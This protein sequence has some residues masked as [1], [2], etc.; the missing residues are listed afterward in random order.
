[1]SNYLSQQAVMTIAIFFQADPEELQFVPLSRGMSNQSFRLECRGQSYH[2]RQP[3][4][5][6][7]LINREHEAAVY[8]AIKPYG[9]CDSPLFLDP[10][11]GFKLSR[12]LPGA[13]PCDPR[14]GKDLDLWLKKIRQLHRA[15]LEVGHAFDLFGQISHYEALWQGCPSIYPDYQETKEKVFE[16]QN[17]I[18]LVPKDWYLTHLDP[19]FDNCLFYQTDGCEQMQL[20][21]WEYAGMQDPHLDLAMFAIYAGYSQ[22]EVDQLLDKYFQGPC[23]EI[24]KNKIYCY[25]AACGLLWSNW[26]EYM[27]RIGKEFGD[28]GLSQYRYAKDYSKAAS[29][30]INQFD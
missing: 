8:Q 27:R 2:F 3:G 21:D 5:G 1:M 30:R 9:F 28:Y 18:S 23:P 11:T 16:L 19:V 14:R 26:C 7:E 4:P 20:T 15:K 10:D 22:T 17:Y 12:F 29:K 13:R 25:I 24:I 6:Q